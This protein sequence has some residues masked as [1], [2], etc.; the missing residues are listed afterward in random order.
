MNE[1]ASQAEIDAATAYEQLFVNALFAEW[2]P[3]VLEASRIEPGA[4]VLDIACGTG[5]LARAVGDGIDGARVVG[6][7]AAPG[8]VAVAKRRAPAI[9]FRLGTAESLPFPDASFDAIVSQFGLM[10]FTDRPAAVSELLRVLRRKGRFAVAVWGELAENAG[11]DT[12]V[13][14]LDQTAGRDAANALRTPFSLG[15]P[16]ELSGLFAGADDVN[17][18]TVFGTARFPSIR[19][20]V[21]AE[22]RGWLPLVSVHLDDRRIDTLLDQAETAL[23]PFVTSKG[24]VEFGTT[25]HIVSGASR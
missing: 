20:M 10:F 13:S 22:L 8:M 14:L 2:A 18:T 24:T 12:L 5:V 9:D 16:A 6:L 15:D 4:R 25:A 17:V 3:R 11:Y 19:V 7:D 21:D 23:A 1:T